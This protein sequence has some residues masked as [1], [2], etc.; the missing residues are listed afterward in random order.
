MNS[1]FLN[2]LVSRDVVYFLQ[3]LKFSE[4]KVCDACVKRKQTRSSFKSTKQV[5]SSR[6]LEMLHMDLCG[7]LKV[8][9]KSE[10]KYILVIVDDYSRFT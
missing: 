3:K 5:I 4:S 10:K 1:S 9:S 6:T 8:Y 7:P 2:K